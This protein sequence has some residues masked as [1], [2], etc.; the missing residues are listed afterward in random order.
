MKNLS[1]LIA[2]IISEVLGTTCLKLS[3]GFSVIWFTVGVV[4]L[5]GASFYYLGKALQY[6]DI[7]VTYA[8]WS[9][10]GCA[11]VAIIGLCLFHETFNIAKIISLFLIVT[12]VIGL[13]LSGTFH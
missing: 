10:V 6:L 12:G 9:G 8:I 2:A 11:L 3:N 7:G 13:N 4:I 5:Y 1:F